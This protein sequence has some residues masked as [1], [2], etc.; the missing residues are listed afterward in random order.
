[1]K[2]IYK[3]C[4]PMAAAVAT[5]KPIKK[6]TTTGHCPECARHGF[7]SESMKDHPLCGDCHDLTGSAL[8][9]QEAWTGMMEGGE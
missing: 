1:M 6:A 7:E 8:V 4:P 5:L 9:E 2:T 3:H